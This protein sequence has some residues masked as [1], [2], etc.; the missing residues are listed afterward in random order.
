VSTGD[1]YQSMTRRNRGETRTDDQVQKLGDLG[2]ESKRFGHVLGVE[3][4]GR[5]EREIIGERG[6]A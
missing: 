6:P 1:E 3:W 2:L 5:D 4:R